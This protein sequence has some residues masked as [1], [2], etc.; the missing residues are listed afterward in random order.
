MTKLLLFSAGDGW[1]TSK[2][3]FSPGHVFVF[4][5]KLLHNNRL[6][7]RLPPFTPFTSFKWKPGWRTERIFEVFYFAC[8]NSLSVPVVPEGHFH[9]YLLAHL[10]FKGSINALNRSN[11][12]G[13]QVIRAM[14]SPELLIQHQWNTLSAVS[15]ENAGW[16][17]RPSTRTCANTARL[18]HRLVEALWKD[19]KD[20]MLSIVGRRC[21]PQS[22]RTRS[23]LVS[24]A[25][26]C[27]H[28]PTFHY[29]RCCCSSVYRLF[30]HRTQKTH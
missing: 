16:M 24:C 23:G 7:F 11:Q 9:S 28:S 30:V 22:V 18:F 13:I 15:W 8:W 5:S 27:S 29:V 3:Q 2:K 12:I 10:V 1:W 21:I 14:E 20:Q 4:R 26:R 25:E 19:N 17:E 6:W